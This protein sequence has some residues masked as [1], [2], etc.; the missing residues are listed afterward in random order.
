MN[1]KKQGLEVEVTLD[2][3]DAEIMEKMSTHILKTAFEKNNYDVP[4][5]AAYV[6]S[7]IG[8]MSANIACS[9]RDVTGIETECFI[10]NVRYAF[11]KTVERNSEYDNMFKPGNNIPS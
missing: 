6:M 1:D 7:F 4:N 5:G 3:E 11:R 8:R 9:M 10:D 2:A